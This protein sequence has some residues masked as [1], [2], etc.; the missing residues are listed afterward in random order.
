MTH[1]TMQYGGVFVSDVLLSVDV[2]IVSDEDCNAYY[3]GTNQ[4]PKVYPSNLCAGN[5]TDGAF[6]F[7]NFRQSIFFFMQFVPYRWR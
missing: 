5:T 4:T 3:G 2:P 7:Y 6:Y 1:V